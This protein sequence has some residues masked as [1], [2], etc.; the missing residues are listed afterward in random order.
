MLKI[1][2]VQLNNKFILAPMAGYTDVAFRRLCKDY[3]AGLTVT[4]MVSVKGLLYSGKKTEELLVR[5]YNE[6]VCAVQLFGSNPYEFEKVITENEKLKDFEIIDIN[7]GCPVPKVTRQ[8]EGSALMTTPEK[9]GEI[10]QACKRATSRPVTVK[11]RLGWDENVSVDFAKRMQDCGADAI[12]V[13]GRTAVQ[14]YRGESDVNAVLDIKNRVNIPLI[15][16]GDAN[17]F[18]LAKY[19]SADGIMVGRGALGHPD[20]FAI[21]QNG[22]ADDIYSMIKKHIEYMQTY[23]NSERYVVANMRKHYAYYL[24]RAKIRA[25][26]RNKVNLASTYDILFPLIEEIFEN[27][28]EE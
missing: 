10:I 12:T 6:A 21:V 19:E 20:V 18:N 22:K 17:E 7:M 5:A 26:M 11:F 8:G 15:I 23:F 25:E 16:S 24:K 1:G 9:A 14:Q 13:H 2:N 27:K 28:K 3:G 4:E